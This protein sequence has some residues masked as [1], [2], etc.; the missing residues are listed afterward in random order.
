MDAVYKDYISYK[1]KLKKEKID[2]SIYRYY[3]HIRV[4]ANKIDS[5]DSENE[6]SLSKYFELLENKIQI[7]LSRPEKNV[8]TYDILDTEKSKTNKL[9]YT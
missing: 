1:N 9:K 3:Y 7:I 8:L 2:A 5:V 6:F 4:M